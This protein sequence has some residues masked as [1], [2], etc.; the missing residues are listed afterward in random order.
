L[1]LP[2]GLGRRQGLLGAEA[3]DPILCGAPVLWAG[4]RIGRF[5]AIIHRG[6]QA[7]FDEPLAPVAHLFVIAVRKVGAGGVHTKA[8]LADV[9]AL[10]IVCSCIAALLQSWLWLAHELRHWLDVILVSVSGQDV[11]FA[12]FLVDLFH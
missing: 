12:R 6:L 2:W 4:A 9:G 1:E 11:F 3:D 5:L 10:L 8:P 7:H